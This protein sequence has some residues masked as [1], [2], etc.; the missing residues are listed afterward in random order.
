MGLELIKWFQ[1][2][3]HLKAWDPKLCA[4]TTKHLSMNI[5]DSLGYEIQKGY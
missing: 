3:H 2:L 5:N 4:M 1:I